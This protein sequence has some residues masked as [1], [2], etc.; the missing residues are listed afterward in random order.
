M[1]PK[2]LSVHAKLR[3][4]YSEVQVFISSF[5]KRIGPKRPV[6]W[7]HYSSSKVFERLISWRQ[8]SSCKACSQDGTWETY[9]RLLISLLA[10]QRK[11]WQ[12]TAGKIRTRHVFLRSLVLVKACKSPGWFDA[13]EKKFC[14]RLGDNL[15]YQRK[16]RCFFL[17]SCSFKFT[18]RA[19]KFSYFFALSSLLQKNGLIST[20][21]GRTG[22]KQRSKMVL[23]WDKHASMAQFYW[24]IFWNSRK[25]RHST[26]TVFQQI[27]L[28]TFIRLLMLSI[29]TTC[30]C[31]CWLIERENV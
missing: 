8:I 21:K 29:D 25:M 24:K 17:M 13:F 7:F 3:W 6:F 14:C 22:W 10:N 26:P 28:R 31:L 20:F 15:S 4:T 23:F 27:C 19:R 1:D 11:N 12:R 2:N 30:K 5:R 18:G 9:V 16:V